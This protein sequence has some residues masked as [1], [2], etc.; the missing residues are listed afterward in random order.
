M[1]GPPPK[2]QDQRRRRNAGD[3]V[4]TVRLSHAVSVPELG[5]TDVHPLARDLYDSLKDSGQSMY[6]EPSDWQRARLMVDMLSNMLYDPIKRS[7]MMYTAIQQ[8]LK[9]LMVCE[10]DRRRLKLEIER[11]P[12]DTSERDARVSQMAAYRRVAGT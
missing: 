5:L 7:S 11:G 12:S 1:P 10:A 4:D 3:P 9:D 2:R 6:Y 8:D